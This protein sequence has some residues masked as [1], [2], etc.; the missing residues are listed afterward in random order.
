MICKLQY[1][2]FPQFQLITS[3]RLGIKWSTCFLEMQG[4][5]KSTRNSFIS[6]FWCTM[7]SY[8][9]PHCL[10]RRNYFS[11]KTFLSSPSHRTFRISLRVTFGSSLIWKWASREYVPQKWRTLNR[12]LRSNCGIFQSKPSSGTF[13]NGRIHE[14][15]VSSCNVPTFKVIR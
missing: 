13:N 6:M 8:Q 4:K 7:S 12:M 3:L 2:D 1:S 5:I 11:R 9:A 15:I 14:G 10:L